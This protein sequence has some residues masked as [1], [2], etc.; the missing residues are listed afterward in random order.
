MDGLLSENLITLSEA[1]ALLPRR[2]RGR[3]THPS[4]LFRWAGQGLRGVRLE[5]VQV[6]GTRCTSREAL[7]RFFSRLSGAND[8]DQSGE[9]R[10]AAAG[11]DHV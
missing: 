5:I 9:P 6:G 4:T 10:A 3:P 2:R 7:A 8:P 11:G 1:A